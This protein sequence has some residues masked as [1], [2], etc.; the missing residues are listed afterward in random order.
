MKKLALMIF[1]S[2]LMFGCS[3]QWRNVNISYS[4]ADLTNNLYQQE[5]SAYSWTAS[6][7]NADYTFWSL[8]EASGSVMYYAESSEQFGAVPSV[9]AVND[10][11]WL[12]PSGVVTSPLGLSSVNI[13]LLLDSAEPTTGALLVSYTVSG[14][15]VPYFRFLA[16]SGASSVGGGRLTLN[17][18]SDDGMSIQLRSSD[19][20]GS[21]LKDVVQFQVYRGDG[22]TLIGKI[23]TMVK[24]E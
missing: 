14:D 23:T 1:A 17:M 12:D 13:Y 4:R 22:E 5:Q 21:R 11:S 3:N 18:I 7:G 19:V 16:S 20:N 9:L 24:V 10:L 15:T 2:V 8:I 6:G